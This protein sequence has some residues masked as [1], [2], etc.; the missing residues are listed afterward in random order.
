M[1]VPLLCPLA[2]RKE[3]SVA[4]GSFAADFADS[5][6]FRNLHQV[7]YHTHIITKGSGVG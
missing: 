2:M 7:L 1:A 4:V 5:N 6:V 3:L